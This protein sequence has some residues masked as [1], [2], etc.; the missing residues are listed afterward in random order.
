VACSNG[1][2]DDA[3]G[4]IDLADP[5][6]SSATDTDET[7]PPAG[8]TAPWLGSMNASYQAAQPG[9]TIVM[10]GGTYGS[11]VI[12]Y[13]GLS[14]CDQNNPATLVTISVPN[15]VTIN[16]NL[17]V[18]GNCVFVKGV[19]TGTM[20]N[21]KARTF[22]INVT[23]YTSIEGDSQ[24]QYPR[25]VRLEGINTGNFGTYS[26]NGV[27]VRDMDVG[28]RLLDLPCSFPENRIG[29]NGATGGV[30]PR[31]VVWERIAIHDQNR[32]QAAA[33]AD[34]HYGGLQFWASENVTLSQ[35]VME[36]NVVYHIDVGESGY[37]PTN[38]K[39]IQSSFSCPAD[40]SWVGDRCDGQK[41][42]QFDA[43]ANY[44]STFTLSGNVAAN[45]SGGLFGCYSEPC[46]FGGITV[47]GNTEIAESTS[48]P[49]VP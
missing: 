33:N 4:K 31:N 14:G 42:V 41:A 12:A 37:G 5:G 44:A 20:E 40:N 9:Q 7:D 25:N 6:C 46:G 30:I 3:D 32:T 10:P 36:R 39:I 19:T 49:A 21:W 1:L 24:S 15:T 26:S 28:P 48:A 45:G 8:G 18:H 23:G 29:P 11:Q 22:T 43:P 34:C 17:E 13:R 38:G 16:G 47:S 2:D 35:I 27:L